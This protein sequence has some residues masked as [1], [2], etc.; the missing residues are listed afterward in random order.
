MFVLAGI[1]TASAACVST[2]C[3]DA[4][5]IQAARDVVQDRCGCGQRG[6]SRAQYAKCAKRT[7]RA[8]DHAAL[9]LSKS[10]RNMVMRCERESVCG[11]P[12]SVVC[13]KRKKSGEVVRSIR[14]SAARCKGTA[15]RAAPNV[16]STFD[17][18]ADDGSC[19]GLLGGGAPG[20]DCAAKGGTNVPITPSGP[21]PSCKNLPE[22]YGYKAADELCSGV[23][24]RVFGGARP[25]PAPWDCRIGDGIGTAGVLCKW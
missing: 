10:C 9:S 19:A 13:C 20:D 12:E 22:A 21:V 16:F 18:C 25:S 2:A 6:Q 23:A 14:P 7:L 4:A 1:G 11:D 3:P 24:D 5:A 17:A 15:C 8:A